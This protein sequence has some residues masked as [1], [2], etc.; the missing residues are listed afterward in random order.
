VPAAHGARYAFKCEPDDVAGVLARNPLPVKLLGATVEHYLFNGLPRAVGYSPPPENYQAPLGMLT[1]FNE[2]FIVAHEYC[3]TLHDE[4]DIVHPG[5]GMHGEEFASDIW[6]FHL[7]VESGQQ[8]DLLPPNLS[9][10][11]AWFVLAARDVIRQALD[12]ARFG[13][14]RDDTG[15]ATHPP[16]ARRLGVLRECYLQSVSPEDGDLSIRAAC[17]ASST[18]EL[19]WR[20]VLDGGV[21]ARWHGRS[22]HRIWEGIR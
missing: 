11:G 2:R 21:A 9:A 13:E 3:H 5:S 16:I 19:L 7:V 17:F 8:F 15:S 12:L 1:N 10:Q 6:A 20:R 14:V 18:L 22:L 4:L